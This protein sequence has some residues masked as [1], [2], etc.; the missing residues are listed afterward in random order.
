MAWTSDGRERDR[1]FGLKAAASYALFHNFVRDFALPKWRP[2]RESSATSRSTSQCPV[3]SPRDTRLAFEAR[4]ASASHCDPAI[5]LDAGGTIA[6]PPVWGGIGLLYA[7]GD[8]DRLGF[9]DL[10]PSGLPP[11]FGFALPFVL[12]ADASQPS[13]GIYLRV[14]FRTEVD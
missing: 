2:R 4:L 12:G 3:I 9:V 7:L 14:M 5:G 10:A 11:R 13:Y 8:G 6:H 1:E